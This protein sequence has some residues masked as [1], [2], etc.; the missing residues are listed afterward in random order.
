MTLKMSKLVFSVVAIVFLLA[1]TCAVV[2]QEEN[3][4]EAYRKLTT[5][6]KGMVG[7]VGPDELYSKATSLIEDFIRKYPDSQEAGQARLLLGQICSQFGDNE[8]AIKYI[9]DFLNSPQA[10]KNIAVKYQALYM[11]A[12][13]YLNLEMFSEARESFSRIVN[14]KEMISERLRQSAR[15]QIDRIEILKKLRIGMPAI[16]FETTG[17]DGKRIALKDFRGKVVL[18]DFWA[19]WCAPCRQEM[20]NV[21]GLYKDFHG[22]GFE[23]IGISL[24]QDRGKLEEYLK[25]NGITWPQIFDGKGWDKS[26]G[27]MYGVMSIP[28]TYL[29]DREGRIRYKNVRG[30][31]LRKAVKELVEGKKSG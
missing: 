8:K 1:F 3:P 23:I 27:R 25:A 31:S 4:A 19:T 7:R 17:F 20:P 26:I 9:N 6:I 18:L 24:D 28:T 21:V 13:S 5:N 12:T 10:G 29:L 2:A 22:K 15:M 11:V 30:E 16:E 14:A